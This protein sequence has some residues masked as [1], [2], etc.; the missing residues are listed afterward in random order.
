M[1][2]EKNI[3]RKIAEVSKFKFHAKDDF[4]FHQGDIGTHFYFVINGEV[5]ILVRNKKFLSVY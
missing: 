3:I 2:L 5:S 4:C 1:S